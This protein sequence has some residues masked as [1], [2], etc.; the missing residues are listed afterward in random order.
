MRSMKVAA[1]CLVLSGCAIER[2]IV[3]QQAQGDMVGMSKEQILE[4]MGPPMNKAAEGATEAWSYS[5]NPTINLDR[6][7]GATRYCNVTILMTA[8]NVSAVRYQGPTGGLITQGE[9]CAYAVDA[10]LKHRG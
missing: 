2:S 6:G 10:C 5:T 4:C 8:G 1:L 7:S 3:A 9:Q